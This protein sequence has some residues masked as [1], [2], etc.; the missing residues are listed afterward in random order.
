MCFQGVWFVSKAA[1]GP[2]QVASSVPSSIYQIPP[3]S[4]SYHVT[5]VTVVEDRTDSVVFATSAGYSGVTIAWGCAVWGTG[6]RYAPWRGRFYP[7]ADEQTLLSVIREIDKLA[8][9]RIETVEYTVQRPRFSGY[10][11]IAVGLW[12]AAAWLKLGFRYCRTFP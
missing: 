7:A 1:T 11:M 8:V 12:L 4:P 6:W 10:L 2:W 3:S 9:G 5:Y